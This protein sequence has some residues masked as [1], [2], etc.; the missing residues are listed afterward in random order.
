[1]VK[2]VNGFKEEL[3]IVMIIL[4]SSGFMV[5]CDVLLFLFFNVSIVNIKMVVIMNLMLKVF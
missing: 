2:L 1:M 3:M 4:I 5:L